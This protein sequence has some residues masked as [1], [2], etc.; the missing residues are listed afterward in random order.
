MHSE[1]NSVTTDQKKILIVEDEQKIADILQDYLQA[2]GY[3]TIHIDDGSLAI[4]AFETHKPDLLILDVMLPGKDGLSLCKEIRQTSLTP[5]IML[6]ARVDEIDRLLGLELGA[7][8]YICKPFS[9]REVV[10]RIKNI[11]RRVSISEAAKPSSQSNTLEYQELSLNFE[12][13]QCLIKSQEQ[14]QELVLTSVEFRL[15][16]DMASHPGIIYS[17]DT[18]MN[19]AYED[20]RIVSDRTIDT[21]IKNIRKKVRD[22]LG[23]KELIH[24]IYGR[25]YKL[26]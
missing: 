16:Y 6:T 8:D 1:K 10:V 23:D 4:Q 5:I 19:I 26:E 11:L 25:G 14:E 18:L 9:P 7:D 2:A 21:H 15:L 3:H 17:R 24:S 22:V 13:Q 12:R 20:S